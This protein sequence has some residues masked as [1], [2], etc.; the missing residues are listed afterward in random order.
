MAA[1]LVGPRGTPAVRRVG[2]LVNAMYG[3]VADLPPPALFDIDTCETSR[4]LGFAKDQLFE[5]RFRR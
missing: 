3:R 4:I 1:R 5:P 2:N